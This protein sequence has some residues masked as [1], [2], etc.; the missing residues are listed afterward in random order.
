MSEAGQLGVLNTSLTLKIAV[1]R[2]TPRIAV[3]PISDLQRGTTPPYILGHSREAKAC[4]HSETA[5]LKIAV[6][7][8]KHRWIALLE[9]TFPR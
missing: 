4:Q 8:G 5:A 7:L 3:Q 9:S 6:H 2:P 1:Q